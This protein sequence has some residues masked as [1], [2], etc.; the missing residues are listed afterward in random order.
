MKK[1]LRKIVVNADVYLY[2][3]SRSDDSMTREVATI[4]IFKDG[5][6]NTPL[7]VDFDIVFPLA[8]SPT[9]GYRI[10]QFNPFVEGLELT[11]SETGSKENVNIYTPKWVRQYIEYA[12]AKGWNASSSE[13]LDGVQI[14][15]EWGYD[16]TAMQYYVWDAENKIT[17]VERYK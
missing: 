12:L 8:G 9:E 16:V 15:S 5:Y 7:R 1:K 11:H 6:K 14:L 2:M 4:T 17:T 13:Q 3:V 10:I